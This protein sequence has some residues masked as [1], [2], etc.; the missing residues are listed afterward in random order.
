MVLP[1]RLLCY[2]GTS[3][4]KFCESTFASW[5]VSLAQALHTG[6]ADKPCRC[7]HQRAANGD[8][9]PGHPQPQL[10]GGRT[11][12]VWSSQSGP[13]GAVGGSTQS[14]SP[15]PSC[16]VSAAANKVGPWECP[17]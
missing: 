8:A 11:H 9:K 13:H 5:K 12:G 1:Y 14:V 16:P 7:P 6:S 17:L 2:V 3:R 4:T 10:A 15:C